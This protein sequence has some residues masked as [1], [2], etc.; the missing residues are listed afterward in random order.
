MSEGLFFEDTDLTYLDQETPAPVVRA[1]VLLHPL[2][3]LPCCEG[4]E[5]EWTIAGEQ[6][7]SLIWYIEKEKSPR[8]LVD[9]INVICLKGSVVWGPCESG[10]V[11]GADFGLASAIA[12]TGQARRR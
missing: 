4:L 7:A 5:L 2:S 12:Y 3:P 11:R 8:D 10:T 9:R 6:F 1:G